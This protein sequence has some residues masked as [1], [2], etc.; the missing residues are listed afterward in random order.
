MYA[1]LL[2]ENKNTCF[3]SLIVDLALQVLDVTLLFVYFQP[4]SVDLALQVLDVTLLFVYLQPES[5][6][7]ALQVLDE[8]EI[9]GKTITVERAKFEMK[10]E[11][12]AVKAKRRKMTNKEKKRLREKQEKYVSYVFQ[13]LSCRTRRL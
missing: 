4:G 8:S 13:F 1:C 5:V 7:L 6:D 12:D 9:R 11:Y 10:G 3:E 2:D